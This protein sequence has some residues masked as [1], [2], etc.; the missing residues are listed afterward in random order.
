MSTNTK[1]S[2]LVVYYSLTK[3]SGRVA[4]AIAAALDA[5]GCNVT[6]SLIEFTD[7]RYA[8]SSPSSRCRGRSPRS[9]ASSR[10]ATPQNRRDHHSTRGP[11]GRLRPGVLASPTWWFQTSMPIRSYPSRPPRKQVLEREAVRVRVDL[12]ALLQHQPRTTE[13]ARREG[14]RQMGREDAFRRRGRTDQVDALVARLYE[15]R[16]APGAR[17]WA[18]DASAEAEAGLRGA[19]ARVRG[20]DRRRDPRATGAAA[21][22]PVDA[23]PSPPRRRARRSQGALPSIA[24]SAASRCST[25]ELLSVAAAI[26]RRPAR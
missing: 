9:R 7:E 1:P 19:G 4:D 24:T 15:A 23:E 14:R 6:K 12:P 3:Q 22:S 5:R 8:T 26:I 2:V 17:R 13:E 25:N 20:R 21:E 18:E 16:R 11:G 10:P